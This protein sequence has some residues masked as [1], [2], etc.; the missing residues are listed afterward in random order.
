VQR[1][2][3]RAAANRDSRVFPN[4]IATQQYVIQ[5]ANGPGAEDD[6]RF[7][8]RVLSTIV[9]DDSGSRFFWTLV[10][11]GRAECAVMCSYEYQGTGIFLTMLCGAPDETAD[12]LQEVL[13]TLRAVQ[14]EGITGDELTQ[15]KNKIC[16]HVV[17]HSERPT[18]R[19]FVLGENW[20]QRHRYQSVRE[21]IES[22]RAVSCDDV[23]DVLDKFPLTVHSTVTVGP[24]R[25]LDIPK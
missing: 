10:D 11:T 4:D 14:R 12:N 3:P 21:I 1:V 25:E 23:A 13:D 8:A 15:A 9:G 22:Y 16:S 6:S 20:L 19:L 17:L 2:T 18:N 24:L 5:I 7:A